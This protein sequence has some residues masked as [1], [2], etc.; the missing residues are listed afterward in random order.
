MI[1]LIV[2]NYLK[3]ALDVPVYMEKPASAP[4]E[5]VLIEKTGGGEDNHIQTATMAIQS[6]SDTLYKAADLNLR[7]I[8]AMRDIVTLNEVSRADRNSDYNFTDTTTKVFRYQAVYDLV[9]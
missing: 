8:E 9:F 2:L 7:V 1:E 4:V 5:Y 3:S 6:I